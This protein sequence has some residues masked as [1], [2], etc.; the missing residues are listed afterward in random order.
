MLTRKQNY[1]TLFLFPCQHSKEQR[2]LLNLF[3]PKSED[4]HQKHEQTKIK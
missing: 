1:H 3:I 4:A 2:N